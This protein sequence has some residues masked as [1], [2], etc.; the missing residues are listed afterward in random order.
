MT[1]RGE[2]ERPAAILGRGLALALALALV[3][4]AAALSAPPRST[5][6][7]LVYNKSRSFR[8]PFHVDP[9]DR[10]LLKEVQLWVSEDSGFSWKTVSRT[11]PDRPFFSFR[12]SHDGEFWF[13]VRTLDTKGVLN[14]GADDKVEPN[15]RVVIDSVPP[16]LVLEP[17]GRRGSFAAVRWE[18]SDAQLDLKSLVLEYQVEGGRDWRTLQ[19]QRPGRFGSE[20]WDAGTAEPLKVRATVSDKAGN[21]TEASTSLPEGTPRNPGAAAGDMA[22]FSTPPPISQISSGPTPTAA[23]ANESLP[24]PPVE[25]APVASAPAIET[26][27]AAS[28]FAT[29]PDPTP[30]PASVA[31]GGGGARQP[32]LVSSPRFPLQYEVNDAGPN[33]P[34]TVEI[35]VTQNGGQS[36]F[37]KGRDEDRKSP[38]WVDLGGEG[39]FGL[40][41]VARSASGLG[42]TPPVSGDAP[43]M[44]VEVDSS[45]PAVQMQ[46]PQV[47]TGKSLGKVRVRWTA[48]DVHLGAKPV[49]ISWRPDQAGARWQQVAGPI[50]NAGYYDWTVPTTVPARFHLR[51]DVVDTAGNRGFAETVESG[52]VVLDRARPR[53]R[54]I[55]L[56]QNA[57]AGMAAGN[58]PLR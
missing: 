19:I 11:T 16:S 36:W 5:K 51:V 43:D 47:G 33:G 24:W 45:P 4:P 6:D 42:D 10:Q 22:D 14:P 28:D 20:N 35:W 1:F 7:H 50:E 9:A 37:Q 12:A 55:G 29:T 58:R 34:A 54:I 23:P 27:P 52:P 26:A 18:A 31:E 13:A 57:R 49:T 38:I 8:I 21:V 41:L 39:T 3:A 2:R 48:S 56:D 30:A 32:E 25:Q 46:P 15:M 44:T 17:D 40:R 53:S